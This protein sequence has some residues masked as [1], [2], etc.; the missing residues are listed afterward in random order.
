M[1]KWRMILVGIFTGLFSLGGA[2]IEP[3]QIE[4]LQVIVGIG[5]FLC[6]WIAVYFLIKKISDRKWPTKYPLQ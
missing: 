4:G 2:S 6:L 5:E 1:D 3:K